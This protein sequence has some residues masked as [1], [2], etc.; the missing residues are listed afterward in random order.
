MIDKYRTYATKTE[1]KHVGLLSLSI[2]AIYQFHWSTYQT[3]IRMVN[4]IGI[5]KNRYIF[6]IY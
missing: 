6:E 1:K 2:T 3:D 5:D 4:F